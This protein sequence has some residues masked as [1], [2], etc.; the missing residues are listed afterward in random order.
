[1]VAHM[2]MITRKGSNSIIIILGIYASNQYR[3]IDLQNL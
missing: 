1:M 3:I 2:C